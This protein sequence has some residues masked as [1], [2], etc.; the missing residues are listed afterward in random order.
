MFSGDEVI[1]FETFTKIDELLEIDE[2]RLVLNFV[3]SGS[4]VDSGASLGSERKQFRCNF[5]KFFLFR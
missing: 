4:F 3:K 2:L 1:D 5:N